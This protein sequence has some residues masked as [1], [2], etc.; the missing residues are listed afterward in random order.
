MLVI[1]DKRKEQL[2]KKNFCEKAY[3]VRYEMRFR[4]EVA[5]A[6]IKK[7]L[8]AYI[9][10]SIPVYG[11][12]IK[13][14]AYELLYG[15]LDIKVDNHYNKSNQNKAETDS[16]WK[17]FLNNVPKVPLP[18][19]EKQPIKSFA[20]YERIA[21]PYAS[22]YLLYKFVE[23]NADT[24]LF[25]IELLKTIRDNLPFSKSRL[26]RLNVYLKELNLAPVDN[27]KL[28]QIKANLSH[29]IEEK[30]LLYNQLNQI[31]KKD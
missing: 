18:K 25:Q 22:A 5:T 1:Y 14:Y 29:K 21:T 10:V 19:I 8:S 24:Y 16:L 31:K 4:N 26:Y 7:L 15:I 6:I 13:Q 27:N 3:W 11:L 20:E 9:D 28:E 23:V 12:N 2:A 30:I 17:S